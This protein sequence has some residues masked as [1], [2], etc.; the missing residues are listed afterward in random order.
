MADPGDVIH[1][2]IVLKT[3]L[4][5]NIIFLQTLSGIAT[6]ATTIWGWTAINEK[7]RKLQRSHLKFD[8]STKIAALE[9]LSDELLS[10]SS[11]TS[12]QG[13]DLHRNFSGIIIQIC[14]KMREIEESLDDKEFLKKSKGIRNSIFSLSHLPIR[15]KIWIFS[16]GQEFSA[17]ELMNIGFNITIDLTEFSDL[18]KM[19]IS[20]ATKGIPNV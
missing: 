3:F 9:K 2:L 11:S 6:I 20:Q 5:D 12:I 14:G 4:R 10:L 13:H 17:H 7:M 1:Y 16:F 8:V 19:R 18:I 15:K